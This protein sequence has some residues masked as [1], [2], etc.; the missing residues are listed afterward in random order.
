MLLLTICVDIMF[1]SLYPLS[2]GLLLFKETNQFRT[3]Q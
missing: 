1:A 3:F 2:S